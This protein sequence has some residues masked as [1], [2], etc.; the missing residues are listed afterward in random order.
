MASLGSPDT[1]VG[2]WHW[3]AL[4]AAKQLPS[5]VPPVGLTKHPSRA[6]RCRRQAQACFSSRT[7]SA[8]GRLT[9]FAP[10]ARPRSAYRH[11]IGA[12]SGTDL[13]V[14]VAS[15]TLCHR[16]AH[17]FAPAARPRSA[18]CR[19]L[20]AHSDR[21][22]VLVASDRHCHRRAHSFAPAAPPRSA[23]RHGLG[24]P[25]GADMFLCVASDTPCHRQAHSFAPAAQ[26]RSATAT[27]SAPLQAQTCLSMWQRT[28]SAT[29]GLTRFR[30]P[31]CLGLLTVAGL[32]PPFE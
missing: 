25:S 7:R 28:R 32:A 27:G 4:R 29:G 12:P 9:P 24:A 5:V 17:S 11:M 13:F 6:E 21:H 19:S 26:P 1:V 22:F 15:D 10:A 2:G 18:Y 31:L 8:T 3:A 14:F 20:G 16:R 23:Y 30:P